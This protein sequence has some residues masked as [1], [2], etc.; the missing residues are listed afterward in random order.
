MHTVALF[1]SKYS[2]ND[3]LTL[4]EKRYSINGKNSVAYS[5]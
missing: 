2:N 1:C 4:L 5:E 3:M